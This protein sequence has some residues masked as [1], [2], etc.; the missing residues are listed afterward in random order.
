[1]TTGSDLSKQ[2]VPL[3][4]RKAQRREIQLGTALVQ[5]FL[6]SEGSY[7]LSQTEVAAVIGKGNVSIIQFL[8][9]KGFK[10]LLDNNVESFISVDPV[11][12][13]GSNKPISP[14]SFHFAEPGWDHWTQ[15]ETLDSREGRLQTDL[16][17]TVYPASRSKKVS[18]RCWNGVV[19]VDKLLIVLF[20]RIFLP[21]NCS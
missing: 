3:N 18:V 17:R 4:N 7:K 11:A 16:N 15:N 8:N 13:E 5:V 20:N 12:V 2:G 6:L 21:Q 14:L 10:T 19:P 9:S 1:M